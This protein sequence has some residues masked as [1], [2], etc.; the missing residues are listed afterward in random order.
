M[1]NG[2]MCISVARNR[3]MCRI[4]PESHD[5]AIERRGVQTV[6]MKRRAYRG[7]V[8]VRADA[9]ASPRDLDYWV[10]ACPQYNKLA[11]ASR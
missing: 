5:R 11:K 9:V 1:V 7:F 3:L 2:K 10:R 4:D 6:Q 8:H